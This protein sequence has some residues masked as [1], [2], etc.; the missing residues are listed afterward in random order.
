MKT[1]RSMYWLFSGPPPSRRSRF[2][3]RSPEA[4]APGLVL[5][6]AAIRTPIHSRVRRQQERQFDRCT[7]LR[8]DQIQL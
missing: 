4:G 2:S 8:H 7:L 1:T 6:S 3:R 5:L